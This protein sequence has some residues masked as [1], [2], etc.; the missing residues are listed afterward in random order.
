MCTVTPMSDETRARTRD[1]TEIRRG[2]ARIALEILVGFV[3]VYAAF[4]LTAYHER[5]A[6]AERR[7]QLKRALI[8]EVR[9]LTGVMRLNF[10]YGTVLAAFD[11][12]LKA[13]KKPI[14]RPFSQ[15]AAV[16][17]HIWEAIKQGGGLTLI[18]VPTFALASD[19]YTD[20]NALLVTYGQLRELS[21]NVILPNMDRGPDPFYN[22]AGK[23]R[24]DIHQTYY[25]DMRSADLLAHRAALEGDSLLKILVRDTL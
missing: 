23:L 1:T 3:G 6:E 7:H 22:S 18:D 15:P 25:W 5:Q 2:V 16:T 14:P 24:E 19:F 17:P 12:A 11:S 4:A 9:E 20:V 21:M 13:G 8:V 10:D